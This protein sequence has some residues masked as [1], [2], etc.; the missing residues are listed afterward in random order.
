VSLPVVA[1]YTNYTI[2]TQKLEGLIAGVIN[3]TGAAIGN[4]IAE[5]D[6][7]KIFKI[8]RELLSIRIFVA[9]IIT[10]CIYTFSSQFIGVWLGN[11]YILDQTTVTLIAI[12][13]GLAIARGVIDQFIHGCGLFADIWAPYAE[14]I[15][16]VIVS[17]TGGYLLRLPGVLYGPLVSIITII[18]I[19]KP[20]YL[21]SRG[22]KLSVF[23]YW[24]LF[25]INVSTSIAAFITT[26]YLYSTFIKPS[27][28]TNSW[29]GLIIGGVIYVTILTI[30]TTVAYYTTSVGFRDF[31][32]RI[33]FK[34]Q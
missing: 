10:A 26:A 28:P 19:W 20:Y 8:F 11:E 21:F 7:N 1:L 17:I 2:L 4:L 16:M 30:T 9:S 31:A 32:R 34:K 22:F 23:I 33:K 27:L 25:I 24:K 3:S 14:S 18:Y 12:M 29:I 15:I 6:K 5:G 13:S